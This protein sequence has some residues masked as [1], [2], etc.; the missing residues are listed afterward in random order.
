MSGKPTV[1]GRLWSSH[2]KPVP[3]CPRLLCLSECPHPPEFVHRLYSR[4]GRVKPGG[5]SWTLR[6]RV[7]GILPETLSEWRRLLPSPLC[8]SASL[9]VCPQSSCFSS[10]RCVSAGAS[11]GYHVNCRHTG[12]SR[13]DMAFPQ[14][15]FEHA[16][17][18]SPTEWTH[19]CKF[20]SE[21]ASAPRE[22]ACVVSD[23]WSSA[24]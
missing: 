11:A 24:M 18:N 20:R 14:C 8:L 1:E 6:S 5:G 21:T 9:P 10:V 19:S 22:F 4:P 13:S 3:L 17:A 15:A 16:F 12:T 2:G 23:G 7:R